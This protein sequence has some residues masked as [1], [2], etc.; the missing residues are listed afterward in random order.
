MGI[1]FCFA[2]AFLVIAFSARAQS[3]IRNGSSLMSKKYRR[4]LRVRSNPTIAGS[5]GRA[6]KNIRRRKG[7]V[8]C[9]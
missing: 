7:N 2:C 1:K 8:R 6:R 4:S 3:D 9:C 5:A